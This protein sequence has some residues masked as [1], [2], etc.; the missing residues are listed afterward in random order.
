MVVCSG[1]S[2]THRLRL[3]PLIAGFFVLILSAFAHAAHAQDRASVIKR[4]ENLER[5]LGVLNNRGVTTAPAGDAASLEVQ[6]AA[7]EEEMRAL[8]GRLE[9]IEHTQ[10]QLSKRFEAFERDM[11][12]R[13]E[14]L[15]SRTAAAAPPVISDMPASTNPDPYAPP[16]SAPAPAGAQPADITQPGEQDATSE[17][18]Q[19]PAYDD[20][21]EHYD[22]AFRLLNQSQYDRAAE[23]FRAFIEANSD[24]VLIGN[25]YYWLGETYYVREQYGRA[26]ER[27]RQGFEAMTDG[28]KAPDNLLK[29]SMSLSQLGRK[30]QACIVLN[31][32]QGQYGEQSAVIARKATMEAAR[33]QCE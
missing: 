11:Q 5:Q 31:Q 32:L 23:L 14:L 24:H 15:E 25:A 30:E 22:A 2:C 12:A 17:A 18:T 33:L 28:P 7:I 8:R 1:D 29:L 9:Q 21:R 16:G 26:A 13:V 3:V 6:L 27:F 10:T 4:I 20:P 19:R